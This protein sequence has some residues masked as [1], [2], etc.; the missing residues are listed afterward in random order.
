MCCFSSTSKLKPN[1][2]WCSERNLGQVGYSG[3]LRDQTRIWLWRYYGKLGN[4]LNLEAEIWA[5]YREFTI[6]LQK[7]VI[8]MEIKLDFEMAVCLFQ[9]RANPNFA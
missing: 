4:C 6:T 2:D 8:R 7:G 9:D 5:M 3:I 1:T